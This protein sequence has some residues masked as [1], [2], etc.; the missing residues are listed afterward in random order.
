MKR[1]G[2]FCFSLL[3]ALMFSAAA[4]ASIL[5]VNCSTIGSPTELA[6]NVVC[7][8][9]N[10]A[11]LQSVQ[12]TVTGGIT[13]SITLTNNS[14]TPQTVSGTTSSRLSVGALAGFS[15]VNTIF[16]ASYTTGSQGL[17]AGQVATFAGLSGSGSGNLGTDSTILAPYIG[18]GTFNIGLSTLTDLSVIGGGGQIASSQSTNA[19]GTA[20]V[21]YTYATS[22]VPEPTTMSLMGLGLLGFGLV[23]RKFQR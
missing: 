3:P 6:G 18:A 7:A 8:Q 4:S 12:I 10:L 5:T 1:F 16:T 17:L 14:T 19:H 2:K 20:E 22:T 21:T 11:G 9:F 13:G 15:F 23:T